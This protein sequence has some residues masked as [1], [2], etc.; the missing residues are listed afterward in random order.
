MFDTQSFYQ[1][2][3]HVWKMICNVFAMYINNAIHEAKRVK[4]DDVEPYYRYG[5]F[6]YVLIFISLMLQVQYYAIILSIQIQQVVHDY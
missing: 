4:E 5:G 3:S 2:E 1:N 6:T